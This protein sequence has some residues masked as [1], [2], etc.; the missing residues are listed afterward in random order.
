MLVEEEGRG[1]GRVCKTVLLG[2]I[3]WVREG[4]VE[5]VSVQAVGGVWER[6]G[7]MN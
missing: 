4:R 6:I 3:R 5:I 2:V 7:D 1:G